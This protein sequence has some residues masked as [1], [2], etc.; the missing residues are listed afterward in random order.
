MPAD[1]TRPV[2]SNAT[3]GGGGQPARHAGSDGP[4]R[5][6]ARTGGRSPS[7]ADGETATPAS[8]AAVPDRPRRRD[9]SHR[10]TTFVPAI[11][12][13]RPSGIARQPSSRGPTSKPT[14]AR[15]G[16]RNSAA[17]IAGVA[18]SSMRSSVH[19]LPRRRRRGRH[20]LLRPVPLRRDPQDPLEA[21]GQAGRRTGQPFNVLLV[22]S[23][24]RAFVNNP[25]RS[26]PSA[27]RRTPVVSAVT[28]PWWP[29]SSRPPNPSP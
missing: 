23:D 27:T 20:L 1:A 22:G 2:Y 29:A 15:R 26:R 17:S 10:R 18:A 5:E 25:P 24:S 8:T 12:G 19:R 7:S 16:K 21:S 4:D 6:H 3:D 14:C 28:S 13:R 11:V 9:S